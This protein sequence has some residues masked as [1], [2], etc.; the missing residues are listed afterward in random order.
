MK[1]IEQN[2][3]VF[4]PGQ[5]HFSSEDPVIEILPEFNTFPDDFTFYYDTVSAGYKVI[6]NAVPVK[7]AHFLANTIKVNKC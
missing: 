1:F 4:V 7:V 5:E 6:G 3:R 2:I